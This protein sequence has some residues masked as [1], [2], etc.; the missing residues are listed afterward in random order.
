MATST[1]VIATFLAAVSL[2]LC[3]TLTVGM[4]PT[5]IAFLFD[6]HPRRYAA[7][8]V[9]AG[10]AAGLVWPVAG[11]LHADLSLGGALH[12]LSQPRNWLLI[13]GGAAIGWGLSEAVPMAARLFLEFRASEAE[14][15]LKKRAAQLAEEWGGEVRG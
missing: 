2:P 11:L 7:C 13:Y 8:A 12:M 4:L 6:R 14:R 9:G 3:L 10:N 5:A 1:I 15:K